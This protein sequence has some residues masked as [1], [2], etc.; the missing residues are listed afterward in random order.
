MLF[1]IRTDHDPKRHPH[2]GAPRSMAFAP[3]HACKIC[4]KFVGIDSSQLDIQTVM[5]NVG[6]VPRRAQNR[7]CGL[8]R[9]LRSRG[10][11]RFAECL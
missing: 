11:R 3:D 4:C 1:A 9:L 2:R 5:K 10:W 7:R 6:C 8:A